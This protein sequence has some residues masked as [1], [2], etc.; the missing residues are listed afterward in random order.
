M[1]DNLNKKGLIMEKESKFILEIN[2]D[3]AIIKQKLAHEIQIKFA[4]AESV[5]I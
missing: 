5:Q 3:H 4:V 1:S 2:A